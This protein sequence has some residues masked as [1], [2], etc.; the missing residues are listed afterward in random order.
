MKTVAIVFL[1]VILGYAYP[2]CIHDQVIKNK[3]LI[4]INDTWKTGRL[5]QEL[6]YGPIRFHY[7]YEKDMDKSTAVGQN[8]VKIM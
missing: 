7:I 6:T 1:V 8:I 5:L 4:P 2:G 3:K